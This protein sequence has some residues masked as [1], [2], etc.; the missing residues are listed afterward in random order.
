MT[1]T[2]SAYVLCLLLLAIALITQLT[3]CKKASVHHKNP[4][5]E[6]TWQWSHTTAKNKVVW[7]SHYKTL[8]F[9]SKGQYKITINGNA[10][11]TGSLRFIDAPFGWNFEMEFKRHEMLY[12]TQDYNGMCFVRLKGTDTLELQNNRTTHL[13]IRKKQNLAHL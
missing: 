4:G 7:A 11:E 9:Q 10:H 1:R 5:L 8:E 2:N 6:G 13:F 3:S 12:D